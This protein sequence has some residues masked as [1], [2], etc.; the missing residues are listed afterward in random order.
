MDKHVAPVLGGAC[1][2]TTFALFNTSL[3]FTNVASAAVISNISPLWVSIAA[4]W[5]LRERFKSQVWI[6][7]LVVFSGVS[8]IM[9]RI[10]D[11]PSHLGIGELMAVD[12]SFFY[13]AYMLITQWGRKKLGSLSLVWINGASAST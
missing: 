8:L 7:L 9:V 1:M 13:A 2:T 10:F 3:S 5:L 12:A 4:W 11:S 6:G